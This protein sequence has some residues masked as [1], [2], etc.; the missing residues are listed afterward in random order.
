MAR[1]LVILAL[2][3]LIY[4]L[5][6]MMLPKRHGQKVMGVR[7]GCGGGSQ[8]VEDK[9]LNDL[10]SSSQMAREPVYD[11]TYRINNQVFW[12]S[13]YSQPGQKDVQGT[14]NDDVV[15]PMRA[16]AGNDAVNYLSGVH[17]VS[18]FGCEK[19]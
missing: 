9:T 13:D 17:L 11:D 19:S 4:V 3:A 5:F 18:R 1:I 2:I 7:M 6:L 14:L 12:M 16:I 10:E 15:T 8:D